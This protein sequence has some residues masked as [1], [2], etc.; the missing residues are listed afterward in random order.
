MIGRPA[1]GFSLLA[2]A[3][4]VCIAW[5]A[6]CEGP[7]AR[8]K[9]WRHAPDPTAAAAGAES[10]AADRLRERAENEEERRRTLR[11]RLAVEPAQL[12]PLLDPDV[13]ALRVIDGTVFEALLHYGPDGIAPALAE[14][15]R[16]AGDGT[17]I[18][19][20]LRAGVNFHDGK[21]LTATDVQ[22]SLDR[23][24]GSFSRVPHLR[25]ALS[26]VAGVE[27]W[28]P[29]DVR[30]RLR[31]PSGYL[32]RALAEVPIVPAAIYE[33]GDPARNAKNRA[34][35]GTGPY[36]FVR[37]ARG[38][39]IAL[40]RWEG[41]WGQRPG[42]DQVE[43]WIVPDGARALML[44]RQGDLD[45]LP[46]LI[47]EHW[48]A[49]AVAPATARELAAVRLAP[50]WVRLGAFD[51]KRAPFD[52]VR[53][54]RAAVLA[55][56]RDKLARD[57]HRGLA[58]PVAGPIFPG[59]PGD[60]P[61]TPPPFNPGVAAALLEDAG[62]HDSDG[63]G[64]RERD[65]QKL[66]V[67]LLAGGDARA[68]AERDL[69]IAGLRRAGFWV[70]LRGGDRNALQARLDAGDFDLALLEYRGH[71]D[72]DLTPLLGAAGSLNRGGCGSSAMDAALV[73]AAVRGLP[74]ARR[75]AVVEIAR[76]LVEDR[77]FLPLVAPDP[78]GLVS[79]R[80]V[81]LAPF[82]GWMSVAAFKPSAPASPR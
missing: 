80:L 34:P 64:I 43:Y 71:I 47:P 6:G 12:N 36:R 62:W 17:E 4:I 75:P 21:P 31:R 77:P 48:P 42:F 30:I 28:G 65:G 5:G 16:L 13:E 9:P 59:G 74:A 78:V 27:M 39:R 52:D 35:V 79:R 76:L 73:A 53:V 29:R 54:R 24:R 37:W 49:E 14:S 40:A 68:D 56:D 82:D 69:V 44:A 67:A 2:R 18:R 23:A 72:E 25:R 19:L 55:V 22:F 41:Y 70:D 26:D 33:A 51:C 8:Q 3:L 57:I 11:I 61:A 46:E 38:D 63:D 20:V 58:R 15:F 1:Q 66:R 10:P 50:A 81:P 7:P 32:L 45:I 60:A